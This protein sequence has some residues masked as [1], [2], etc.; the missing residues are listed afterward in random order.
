MG[1]MHGLINPCPG[2]GQ[3]QAGFSNT[4]GSSKPRKR[5][6]CQKKKENIFLKFIVTY[7]LTAWLSDK[8]VESLSQDMRL[9]LF[10]KLTLFYIPKLSTELKETR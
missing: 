3:Y 10:R 6:P 4:G 1:H 2:R 8:T 7:Q 5:A 9:D